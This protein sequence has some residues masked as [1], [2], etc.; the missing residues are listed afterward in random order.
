VE[1]HFEGENVSNAEALSVILAVFAVN[2]LLRIGSIILT[3]S[4][5]EG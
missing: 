1:Y 4:R 3:R 2:E 5:M